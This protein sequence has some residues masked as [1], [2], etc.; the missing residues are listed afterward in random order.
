MKLK[1]LLAGTTFAT[2]LLACSAMAQE[3]GEQGDVFFWAQAQPPRVTTSGETHGPRRAGQENMM[4]A[5]KPIMGP[6]WKDSDIANQLHLTDQQ[7]KDI[8][9]AFY[10]YRL[11]LID[12]TAATEK[13]DMQLDQFM[14]ADDL[15]EDKINQTLNQ[16]VQARGQLTKIY[17]GMLISIRKVLQ[18][19]QWKS[20]Q[21]LQAERGPMLMMY[22]KGP[23]I[24][25][26]GIPP[27]AGGVIF[28]RQIA[29]SPAPAP[30]LPFPGAPNGPPLPPQP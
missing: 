3:P 25:G 22:P 24:F 1:I 17:A 18:P 27:A 5:R 7:K 11:Q 2:L 20:L 30:P 6:W 19:E 12:A 29:P 4:F 13:L 23:G 15:Q 14:N 21:N 8:D 9:Q 28:H 26:M 10:Q 16:L